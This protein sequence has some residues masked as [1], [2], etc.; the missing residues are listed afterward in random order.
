[1]HPETPH[2]SD[3]TLWR[4]A[5]DLT[6]IFLLSLPRSGSTLLQRL[7][8]AHEEVATTSEPWFLLPLFYAS[9]DSGVYAEY[10]HF[11]LAQ[12]LQDFL[13]ELPGGL[14]DYRTEV[15]R[16]TLSV[17]RKAAGERPRYFLDKTPRYHLVVED[18]FSTFPDAKFVFLWRNPLAVVASSVESWA[19]G[20][21]S[22]HRWRI[23]LFEGVE[24]L[25]GAAERHSDSAFAIRYEDLVA[26]P[27]SELTRVYRYLD[28]DSSDRRPIGYAELKGRLGD[29]RGTLE[30]REV[31]AEPLDKWKRTLANP[32]RKDWCRRY[33]RW[34]GE[35]RLSVMGYALDA[36]LQDLD[37]VPPRARMIPSDLLRMARANA[38]EKV[39]K[40][41]MPWRA[42]G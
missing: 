34:I 26:N 31:T 30:Y 8:A 24:N 25:V 7:I 19:G 40:R 20:R 32:I 35:Q 14:A 1:V 11:V 4:L 17:Y 33:L 18:L 38:L 12:A 23:D 29:Q 6:P 42:R 3:V 10:D 27:E 41:V 15:R 5:S 39:R 9:R 36:L 2:A 21:W 37:S 13:R 28:L 16:F 22:L